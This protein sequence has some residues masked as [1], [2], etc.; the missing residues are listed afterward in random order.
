LR[1]QAQ[2][3]E[4]AGQEFELLPGSNIAAGDAAVDYAVPI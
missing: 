2:S 3:I 4:S 1:E